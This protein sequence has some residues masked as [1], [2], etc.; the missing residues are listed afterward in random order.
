MLGGFVIKI[1]KQ[2][3]VKLLKKWESCVLKMSVNLAD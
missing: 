2:Q 1:I 3:I